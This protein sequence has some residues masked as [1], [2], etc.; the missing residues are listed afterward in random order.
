MHLDLCLSLIFVRITG[1]QLIDAL[2]I[3]LVTKD[4]INV[5]TTP[6]LDRVLTKMAKVV[7]I[8]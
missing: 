4:S 3:I 2:I 5:T 7:N 1:L 6:F 8:V